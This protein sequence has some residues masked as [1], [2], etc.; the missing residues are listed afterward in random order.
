MM[1]PHKNGRALLAVFALGASLALICSTANSV[2]LTG[3]H[4]NA[5]AKKSIP[6]KAAKAMAAPNFSLTDAD[7]VKHSLSDYRGRPVALYFFCGCEWCHRTA[8]IWGQ[9]QHAG[10]LPAST[11]G[12]QPVT[13][14]VFSGDAAAAKQFATETAMDLNN[15]VLLTDQEMHVTLDLYNAEPCPRVFVINPTGT[16]LYTNNHKD[17]QARKAPEMVIA[18]RALDALRKAASTN[19]A[20]TS[21][22]PKPA[23]AG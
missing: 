20:S 1:M 18:S 15:T 21:S 3:S 16:V 12:K 5:S 8:T 2:P 23:P 11:G 17:D 22:T 10:A 9:M 6:A 13:L 4:K 19:P 14:V 7:G